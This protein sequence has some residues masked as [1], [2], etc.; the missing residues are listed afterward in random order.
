LKLEASAAAAKMTVNFAPMLCIL[1]IGARM[2]ALQIDPKHGNPQS[3]A[4]K[5]F[6]MCTF[7]IL[8]Q[9]LVVILIPFM[10][11]GECKRGKFEGDIAFKMNNPQ[12]GAVMTT[13]R[14]VCLLALYGGVA[15]VVYSIYVIEHPDGKTKT[16]PVSPAMHCVITLTV[17]YFLIYICLF[18]C[19]TAKSFHQ[20]K[21]TPDEEW[22]IDDDTE[23][24]FRSHHV[25]NT[26]AVQVREEDEKSFQKAMSSAI[27]IFDAARN[28]VMFAPML[29][30]LFIGARMRALQLTKAKNGLIP[31]DAGPQRW[32]QDGMEMATWSVFV[33]LIMT[34]LVPILTSS[35]AEVGQDGIVKVAPGTPKMLAITVEVVRYLSLLCMYGGAMVVVY[36]VF[37]MTPENL[38]PYNQNNL[39]PGIDIPEAPVPVE[40]AEVIAMSRWPSR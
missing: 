24:H 7:S 5:C 12:V 9:A 13:A 33:Q 31:A 28:T 29:S 38:P 39:I 8:I 19:I 21:M 15:V 36:G 10:A 32:V 23:G 17:Q 18:I 22:I 1:F 3:W 6:F 34:M 16:P 2:R 11:K 37:T 25:D 40:A 4:Q 30:I 14:Y 27:A 26:M 20:G 35:K